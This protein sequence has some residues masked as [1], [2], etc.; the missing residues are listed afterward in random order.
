M[1]SIRR[2]N[3][4]KHRERRVIERRHMQLR[5]SV[6]NVRIA[7]EPCFQSL[8]QRRTAVSIIA[9]KAIALHCRQPR[10]AIQNLDLVNQHVTG[11]AGQSAFA[12]AQRCS[13]Q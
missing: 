12:L 13:R 5:G 2:R 9:S 7:W 8:Q 3:A 11:Q 4:F 1:H 6:Q 10:Q